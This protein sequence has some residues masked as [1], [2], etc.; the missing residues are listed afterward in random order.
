MTYLG[1]RR[2]VNIIATISQEMR[3]GAWT[4]V[5]GSSWPRS[6]SQVGSINLPWIC[7]RWDN[8]IF[9]IKLQTF[10]GAILYSSKGGGK[11]PQDKT[12]YYSM[13]YSHINKQL[14]PVTDLDWKLRCP[15][16]MCMCCRRR[17]YPHCQFVRKTLSSSR[18]MPTNER[19][20]PF[21][22]TLKRW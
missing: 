20:R 21:T 17:I 4:M 5:S 12:T 3:T 16:Y 11:H 10:W 6:F 22:F 9:K 8:I 14:C 2:P 18:A 15:K 1:N 13:N 19:T 7:G